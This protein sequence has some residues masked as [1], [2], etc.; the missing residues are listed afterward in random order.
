MSPPSH[1]RHLSPEGPDPD[2]GRI[3]V[4]IRATG[5]VRLHV[6]EDLPAGP[7]PAVIAVHGYR[8][9]PDLFF[10][11]VRD[12]APPG[13]VVIAPEGP[14]AFYEDR[15]QPQQTGPRRIS[16]GWI[17]DPRREDAE[18]RNRDLIENA[19]RLAAERR[20]LD[21]QRTVMVAF[22]QGVGVAVD[23]FVHAP[24]RVAA[25]AAVAGGVPKAGRPRLTALAG[26][27]ILWL[28]GKGDRLYPPTYVDAVFAALR[29][30]GVQ[31]E[32]HQLDAGHQLLDEARD[33][34]GTWLAGQV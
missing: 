28:T 17:A 14:A 11:F 6:P 4:P 20:V 22:S 7:A 24:D 30:A 12:L 16:Y 29:E 2:D 1:E 8:Q 34:L 31:L 5:Y 9:P 10:E 19:R 13:V 15:W 25:L 21:P 33:L 26:R 3:P 32:T 27:P 23:Y 18:A